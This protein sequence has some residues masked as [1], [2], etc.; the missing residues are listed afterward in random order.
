MIIPSRSSLA[1]R[2]RKARQISRGLW[3][4]ILHQVGG[5]PLALLDGQFHTCPKCSSPAAF[6]FVCNDCGA[7]ECKACLPM[8]AVGCSCERKTIEQQN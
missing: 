4:E 5:I 2:A 3:R 6:R 7:C 8:P 1:Y